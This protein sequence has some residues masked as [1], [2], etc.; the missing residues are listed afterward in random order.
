MILYYSPGAC[1][2]VPHIALEEAGADYEAQAGRARRRRASD[3]RLSRRSIRMPGCR[4]WTSTGRWS[5]RM[6]RSSITSRITGAPPAPCRS[7]IIWR[8]RGAINCSAGS[9]RRS[10]SALPRSG[11]PERFTEDEAVHPVIQAGGH[12]VA[13]ALFR[14]DR[15]AVRRGWI[16]PGYFTAADSYLL[17]FF[18]WGRRIGNDMSVYPR[19]QALVGRILER[20]RSCGHS[21]QKALTRRLPAR[22]SGRL[23][24]LMS[25]TKRYLT[26]LF[27]IRS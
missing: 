27:S 13:E 21:R 23:S 4:R 6:S 8:R 16:V 25:M 11:G 1:S 24:E 19:W 20:A 22:L 12:E 9:P 5:P 17:I 3:S 14:R 10:T 7:R 18:R 15:G 26:S 2:L